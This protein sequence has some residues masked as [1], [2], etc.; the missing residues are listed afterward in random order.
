M[1]NQTEDDVA[2]QILAIARREARAAQ[3][4]DLSEDL[5]LAEQLAAEGG[6]KGPSRPKQATIKTHRVQYS[7]AVKVASMEVEFDGGDAFPK[8][9]DP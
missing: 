1:L 3:S 4:T 6:N 7:A 2:S 9:R 5:A 8:P